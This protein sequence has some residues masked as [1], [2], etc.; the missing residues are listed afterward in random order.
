MSDPKLKNLKFSNA[1]RK[2]REED[3]LRNINKFE[4]TRVMKKADNG[5]GIIQQARLVKIFL[6]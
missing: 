4:L 3:T 6:F 5:H 1:D 2:V